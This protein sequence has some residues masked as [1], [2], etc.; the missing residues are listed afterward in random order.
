[1]LIGSDNKV[2][3]S[4]DGANSWHDIGAGIFAPGNG[5]VVITALAFA[6]SDPNTVY[7]GT[8]DGRIFGTSD[9]EESN[10]QWHEV[11]GGLPVNPH[12]DLTTGDTNQTVMDLKVDPADPDRV[13]AVTREYSKIGGA[14]NAF[15]DDTA[16]AEN[17]VGFDHFWLT[18]SGGGWGAPGPDPGAWNAIN[19][20]MPREVGG[21]SLAVD[22][23]FQT[24]ILYAGTAR[25]VWTSS[26]LGTNWAQYA[27]LPNTRVTDLDFVPELDL[28][29]AATLGRGAYELLVN[30]PIPRSSSL[31]PQHV[32]QGSR[33]IVLKVNG[34]NFVRSSSVEV[35]GKPVPT[36]FVSDSELQATLDA[37][38]FGV[39]GR[40][41]ISVFTPGPGGGT[42]K[43]VTLTI[44]AAPAPAPFA[45]SAAA[46]DVSG[47]LLG[48]GQ[49]VGTD[50]A[51]NVYTVGYV[52]GATTRSDADGFVAKYS[53]DG[54]LQWKQIVQGLAEGNSFF[55]SA[56]VIAVDAAGDS[57]VAGTFRATL[58]LGNFTLTS[59]GPLDVFVEKLDT[60]GN[61]K[62]VHQFANIGNFGPP[63]FSHL[64]TCCPKS[65]AI[66]SA[67]EVVVA[68]VFTGHLDT[69]PANPGQ[70]FLDY[71]AP[72]Q[73][74]HPD[75]YL[76]KLHA[77]GSFDWQA[78]VVNVP[79]D[80]AGMDAVAMD[81]QGNVY[82][83]GTLANDNYFNDATANNSILQNPNSIF[84]PTP[85]GLANVSAL[86]LWK[87]NAD[88]T[89]AFVRLVTSQPD[90]TDPFAGFTATGPRASIWGLGLAIDGQGN[91]NATGAFNDKSVD[92]SPGVSFPGNPTSGPNI[93][94]S[95]YGNYD[96]FV[97]KM[98]SAGNWQWVRQIATKTA[99]DN[100]GTGLALDGAG[101]PYIT[102]YLTADS[103]VGNF[104]LTP[105]SADG[106][107]YI[108]E[109]SPQGQV[110]CAQKSVDLLPGG[111]Q[112][113]GIAVDPQ[114][115][116]DIAGSFA[117][118]MQWPGL[119]LTNRTGG[120]NTE[121]FTV[122][123]QLT[124]SSVTA[125]LQGTVLQLTGTDQDNRMVITDDRSW[126]ILIAL[127]QDPLR[128]YPDLTQIDVTSG[129]GD[130]Q[131]MVIFGRTTATPPNLRFQFGNGDDAL[132]ILAA[133]S[134]GSPFNQVPWTINAG[135]GS[136]ND[137]AQSFIFGSVPMDLT[138]AFGSGHNSAEEV[139]RDVEQMPLPE[140]VT[141]TGGSGL[142]DIKV[143]DEFKLQPEPSGTP[144]SSPISVTVGG[145]GTNV[146]DIEH[147][148]QPTSAGG[149]GDRRPSSSRFQPRSAAPAPT[150]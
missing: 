34:A 64:G 33:G 47:Q 19:G 21:E 46:P 91:I 54:V 80:G 146:V 107:S 31:N 89:N 23:R 68:G 16:D 50:A 61:V 71:P 136:G 44:T 20:N 137:M 4:T 37:P 98:D 12:G 118:Q 104:L 134:A 148:F 96:T 119:P 6:P 38:F 78:Q 101:N 123:T 129:N 75:G 103:L 13:F 24:P 90:P 11:D 53:A 32:V 62:W 5:A 57:Y 83:L 106:N 3:E 9:A 1:L 73:S 88:G 67:G 125:T 150:P 35:N 29:G 28:L 138:T 60:N 8:Y 42:S 114:G 41:N 132:S 147:D 149:P 18:S 25:G 145:P 143:I 113:A 142:N 76:V 121:I 102:G 36:T 92:F 77:D 55:D 69:D 65:I 39:V 140:Q 45:V 84:V 108:A 43:P 87:L 100:W 97:E 22:W 131:A 130:D 15:R 115:F 81:G 122:K 30:A 7:A 63:T 72:G 74:G 116:V 93:V 99:G 59:T 124:C 14:T 70:H 141:V 52:G 126:G 135:F 2:Y 105:A 58:Q 48:S 79:R 117:A 51:G 111:D 112:A 49:G 120:A 26:D 85:Q 40:L 66:D 109:L 139:F 144:Q 127:D 110:L 128:A 133:V 94:T 56:D 17:L 86:F 10:P 95:P 82:A 27:S